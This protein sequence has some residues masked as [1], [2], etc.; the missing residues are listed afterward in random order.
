MVAFHTELEEH[1]PGK[2]IVGWYHTHPKRGVFLSS[3]DTWLHNNFFSEPWQVALV[4]EPHSQVGGVFI[5]QLDGTLDPV[6]YSGF[7]E[8]DGNGNWSIVHWRNL[9]R[10]EK[11]DDEQGD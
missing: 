9:Q 4:I 6:R 11:V 3:Y 8:L 10:V 7:H 5:R 1:F 2:K